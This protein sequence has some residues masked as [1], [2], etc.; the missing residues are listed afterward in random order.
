[1]IIIIIIIIIIKGSSF[2]DPNVIPNLYGFFFIFYYLFIC[3]FAQTSLD[4]INL[5]CTQKKNNVHILHFWVTLNNLNYCW[6]KL[7]YRYLSCTLE[8]AN[9]TLNPSKCK[10]IVLSQIKIMS[11]I[12]TTFIV[13]FGVFSPFWSLIDVDT[14][15]CCD[16]NAA[17]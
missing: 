10:T 6:G 17:L 12:W 5:Y 3:L 9:T 2:A 14:M 4:H 1:M 7:H 11:L 15:N 16:K 8:I 13:L